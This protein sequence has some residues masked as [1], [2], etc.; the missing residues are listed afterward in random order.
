MHPLSEKH[1]YLKYGAL[2]LGISQMIGERMDDNERFEWNHH[3][4]EIKKV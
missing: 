2:D 4:Y 1:K 3:I